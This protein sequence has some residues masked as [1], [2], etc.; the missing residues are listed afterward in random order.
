MKTKITKI[1]IAIAAAFTAL[2]AINSPTYALNSVDIC[3]QQGISQEVR[4]ANGCGGTDSGEELKNV[5]TGIINGVIG[6]LGAVAAIFILIGGINYMTSAGDPGKTKKAKDT[7]LW[8]VIGLIIAVLTFAIV[9]LVI[10]NI[11][12]Q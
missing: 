9:N 6:I 10:V 5:I 11:L 7:I 8:A 2:I 3:S 12:G 4:E 1:I